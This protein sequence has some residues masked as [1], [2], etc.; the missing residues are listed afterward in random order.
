MT[1]YPILVNTWVV[2][3]FFFGV[4]ITNFTDRK[5]KTSPKISKST[6][7]FNRFPTR[8]QGSRAH[9]VEVL[10]TFDTRRNGLWEINSINVYGCFMN[11]IQHSLIRSYRYGSFIINV[12]SLETLA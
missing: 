7:V 11:S 4:K 3:N 10:L 6:V 1:T 9:S 12:N 5:Q 2:W 8:K